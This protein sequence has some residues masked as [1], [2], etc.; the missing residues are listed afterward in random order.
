MGFPF[1]IHNDA[2]GKKYEKLVNE[3][4]NQYTPPAELAQAGG[5]K[6]KNNTD[7]VFF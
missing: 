3:F 7:R 2:K 4:R 1:K 6:T 5:R